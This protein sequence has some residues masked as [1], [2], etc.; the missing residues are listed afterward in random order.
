MS[1]FFL[2][3]YSPG[4]TPFLLEIH[5]KK[6]MKKL[7]PNKHISFMLKKKSYLLLKINPLQF[8]IIIFMPYLWCQQPTLMICWKDN[9][10]EKRRRKK[11]SALQKFPISIAVQILLPWLISVNSLTLRSWNSWIFISRHLGASQF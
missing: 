10:L 2:C 3:F 1:Y 11:D 7:K 8:I 5:F 6:T 9:S 4:S